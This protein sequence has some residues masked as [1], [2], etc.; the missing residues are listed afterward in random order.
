MMVRN[1]D[2]DDSEAIAGRKPQHWRIGHEIPIALIVTLVIQ[3]GAGVVFFTNLSNKVD[4]ALNLLAE[5]RAERYTK[6][7][8]RRDRELYQ[9]MLQA[10]QAADRETDRRLEAIERKIETHIITNGVRPAR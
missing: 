4:A 8:A 9:Q 3:T 10:S 5:F 7:D 1:T 2:A 6:E